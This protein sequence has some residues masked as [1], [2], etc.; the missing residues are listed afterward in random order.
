MN[1][2]LKYFPK[3]MAN[4]AILLYIVLVIVLALT[5][6]L[7]VL[8][9]QWIFFG[10]FTVI[11]FFS[12]SSALTKK[13]AYL[14]EKIF[15]KKVFWLALILRLLWIVFVYY[16]FI[17]MLGQPF[18][19]EAADSIGCHGEAIWIVDL[20]SRNALWRYLFYI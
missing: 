8:D 19:F 20:Y 12:R 17:W 1:S 9:A 10:L 14:P 16:Y 3:R 13:W 18:E 6:P 7:H 4:Q 15:L 11:F 2:E 5:F